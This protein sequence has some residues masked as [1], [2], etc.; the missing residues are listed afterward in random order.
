MHFCNFIIIGDRTDPESAVADALSPFDENWEVPPY[1]DYLDPS[2]IHDMAAHYG[3]PEGDL[4]KL[5]AKMRDWR[6]GQGGV[7]AKG[8]YALSTYNPE[9]R[10]D[11]Y[12]I[13]G[14]WDGYIPGSRGNVVG[15]A[16]LLRGQRLGKCL[17]YQIT[18]PEGRWIERPFNAWFEPKTTADRDRQERWHAR[19]RKTL[20]RYRDHKVVCVDTHR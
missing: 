8:L 10:W 9:G 2:D 17:P 20:E 6:G 12:E 3:I 16:S 7:D 14:R 15:V 4:P 1:R 19:V 11:W 18:T 13:G 5:A